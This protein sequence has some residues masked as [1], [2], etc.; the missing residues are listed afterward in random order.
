MR[1][2]PFL[3]SL[4]LVALFGAMSTSPG[5][6]SAQRAVPPNRGGM[7]TSMGAPPDWRWFAGFSG[8]VHRKDDSR[9]VLY[10]H[11]SLYRH[12]LNPMTGA[13][14]L[15]GDAYMGY[16]GTFATPGA[17]MDGGLRLSFHSPV[18]RLAAG[19]D[20]NLR[21]GEGDV[22]V[23]FIHPIK[24]GGIA[25]AGGSLRIDYLPG[26]GH[27]FAVGLHLPVGQDFVGVT[28]PR[29]DYVE[30]SDPTPRR[31]PSS[32][33]RPCLTPSR[34]PPSTHTG[35]GGSRCRSRISGTGTPMRPWTASSTRW[36][37]PGPI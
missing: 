27:S 10:G 32:L 23:S 22:L 36:R 11:G 18:L 8:G 34:R 26:R 6:L 37:A 30:F 28:R 2:R 31:S 4:A 20:Y 35:S 33:S 25:A 9:A 1:G 7:T 16:R 14:G 24:R 21:D 19:V 15:L 5:P 29:R 13:L 12:L 3:G 17:G